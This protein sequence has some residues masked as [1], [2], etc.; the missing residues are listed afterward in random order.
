MRNKHHL[1]ESVVAIARAEAQKIAQEVSGIKAVVIATVDGFDIASTV[2]DTTDPKR[3]AAM[4]SS[5]SAIGDVVSQEAG[6]GRG[7]NIIINTVNGFVVVQNVRHQKWELVVNV[8]AK[9]S[10]ILAQVSYHTARLAQ[11]LV[12]A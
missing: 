10:A 9:D 12:A 4:A 1:P 8:V 3:I 5:I 2:L 6:L 7:K 11:A